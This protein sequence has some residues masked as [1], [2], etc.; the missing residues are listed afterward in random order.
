[1]KISE[2]SIKGC[3][4]ITLESYI[5]ERGIFVKTFNR[6]LFQGTKL[7][8]F[9]MEEE[10]FTVSN[11][12]VIRGLHFQIPPFQH[13]K[14]VSCTSGEVTDVLLDIR[15][16][17]VTYGRYCSINLNSKDNQIIYIPIGIAH[18]FI[19]RSNKS[20]MN[21]KVDKKYSAEYDA[22]IA[23]DSFSYNWNC[24]APIISQRDSKFPTLADFNSPF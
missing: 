10:F 6:D 5:D 11:K 20:S 12:N 18:G 7:E 13:N 15:K 16:D 8:N 19:S 3:F 24:D 22:G 17:S 4:L 9:I 1:M 23:W 21:Y 2:L 14:L